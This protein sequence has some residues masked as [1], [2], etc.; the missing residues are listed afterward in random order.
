MLSLNPMFVTKIQRI[1][2]VRHLMGH[3]RGGTV[4]VKLLTEI[5]QELLEASQAKHCLASVDGKGSNNGRLGSLFSH[6]E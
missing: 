5:A 3:C 6:R 4:N 1:A 2:R